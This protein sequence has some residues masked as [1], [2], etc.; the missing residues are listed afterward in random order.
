MRAT[1]RTNRL[2]IVNRVAWMLGV[3]GLLALFTATTN[4]Y[5]YDQS[6]LRRVEPSYVCMTNNKDMGKAQLPVKVGDQTYY[7][8]CKMCAGNL[9]KN[10]EARQ[11]IDPVTGNKVD[12]AKAIIGAL[13]GGDVLY[14][15]SEESYNTFREGNNS[16][17]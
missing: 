2:G 6:K 1:E 15:E 7:G 11:A 13:A 5:S 4:A 12:K 8:C 10:A 9:S 3:A 14:F 17:L 16:T